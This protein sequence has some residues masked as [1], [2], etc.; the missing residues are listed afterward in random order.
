MK[1]LGIIGGLGPLAGAHFYERL[2]HF[3]PAAGDAGHIPTILISDPAIPS[4]ILH[5]TGRGTSPVPQLVSVAK[6]L[7]QGGADILAIPSTTTSYYC[8]EIQS[9]ISVPLISLIG[10]V[11][12]TLSRCGIRNVGILATTPTRTHR[13]YEASFRERDIRWVYPD[14]ASQRRVMDLITAVKGMAPTED[15]RNL[16]SELHALIEGSWADGTDAVLLGCTELPVIWNRWDPRNMSE[17]R[18]VFSATDILA[19]TTVSWVVGHVV[20]P[21]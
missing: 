3:T 14:D 21:L 7:I 18:F 19:E 6:R 9:Q 10:A 1:T 17:T 12:D 15:A 16:G 5:L 13:I 8:D 4:R 11:R 2:V 20:R